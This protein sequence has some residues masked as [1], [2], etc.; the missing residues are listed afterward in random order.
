LHSGR[1]ARGFRCN[2]RTA[3]GGGQV[4]VT[5][6]NPFFPTLGTPSNSVYILR[7]RPS[8]NGVI[9]TALND[10]D[11][12]AHF[13]SGPLQHTVVFGFEY[14]NE[15]A[16]LVRFVNQDTVITPQPILAPD[17]FEAFPG[18]QT[19]VNQTPKTD[20]DTKGVYMTDSISFGPQWQLT[21]AIRYDDFHASFSQPFGRT[22]THFDHTDIIWSPRGA[23]VYKPT[24]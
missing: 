1:G 20:T 8:G 7:D 6:N 2:D 24:E 17:P 10:L 19:T 4:P 23:L 3:G 12:T 16:D 5:A 13:T 15:K 11:A 21:G 18:T 9:Q 14:D 22:P